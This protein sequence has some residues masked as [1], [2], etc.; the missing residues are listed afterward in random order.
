MRYLKLV[1]RRFKNQFH[2][3]LLFFFCHV[4]LVVCYR[5]CCSAQE[6]D[7]DNCL[8]GKVL[9]HDEKTSFDRLLCSFKSQENITI[10]SCGSCILG[11]F[12]FFRTMGRCGLNTS[13][14]TAPEMLS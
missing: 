14:C 9:L 6:E 13:F 7:H 3:G 4:S 12:L 8:S 5:P 10:H 11:T 2:E 1:H